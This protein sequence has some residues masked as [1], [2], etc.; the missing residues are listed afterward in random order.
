MSIGDW[1]GDDIPVIPIGRYLF[2]NQELLLQSKIFCFI[3]RVKK[4]IDYLVYFSKEK[5]IKNFK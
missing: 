5:L 3:G 2:S 1:I 4:L